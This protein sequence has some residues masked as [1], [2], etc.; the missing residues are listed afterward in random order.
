MNYE[1]GV[2]KIMAQAIGNND[3]RKNC[4][5]VEKVI[6][7]CF[8]EPEREETLK[9]SEPVNSKKLS[10]VLLKFISKY[11]ANYE[12]ELNPISRVKQNLVY[13]NYAIY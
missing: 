7:E 1:N 11:N 13:K 6:M 3:I 8:C 12:Q 10:K 5:D 2:K 9:K 4:V